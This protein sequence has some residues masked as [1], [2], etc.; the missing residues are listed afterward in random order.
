MSRSLQKMIHVG[1]RELGLDR[2]ARHALQ[3]SVTG[4]DSLADMSEA[5]L[6]LIVNR[7]KQDGFRPKSGKRPKAPRKDL[8]LI[9][10][11][12][13]ELG[14]AGELD[15][16]GRD[17]LNAFIRR[18][19]EGSWGS[20]PADVDMLRD[21]KQIDDVI[22]ALKSWADRAGILLDWEGRT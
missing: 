4:K 9:H 1:C 14:K 19:F 8:R 5:E 10:V 21:W 22:Q 20:V 11:L 12:W 2:E 17:G 16:P 7:L 3:L 13:A 6:T 15:K 18:R